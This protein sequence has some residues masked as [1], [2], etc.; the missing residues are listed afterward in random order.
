MVMMIMKSAYI[1]TYIHVYVSV[2]LTYQIPG[3]GHHFKKSRVV[4]AWGKIEMEWKYNKYFIVSVVPFEADY[5]MKM[6]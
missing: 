3:I 6:S 2:T 4:I 1:H 5:I